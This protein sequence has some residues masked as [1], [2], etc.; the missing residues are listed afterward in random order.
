MN[1]LID[2]NAEVIRFLKLNNILSAEKQHDA[3]YADEN[4][5]LSQCDLFQSFRFIC[6]DLNL[7]D[8][9]D[10]TKDMIY[11]LFDLFQSYLN[12]NKNHNKIIMIH[13]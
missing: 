9:A 11:D 2:L 10:L 7:K 8:I 3:Y 6:V 13:A 4:L 1:T 12:N 5:N